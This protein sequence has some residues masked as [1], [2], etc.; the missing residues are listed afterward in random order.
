MTSQLPWNPWIHCAVSDQLP[1][2]FS[3]A[4]FHPS[5]SSCP[6]SQSPGL[7]PPG[8]AGSLYSFASHI[9]PDLVT[10]AT[11]APQCL[12]FCAVIYLTL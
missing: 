5:T 9:R 2:L 11:Q 6:A 7:L 4:F 8:E 10:P 3:L 12:T 1:D